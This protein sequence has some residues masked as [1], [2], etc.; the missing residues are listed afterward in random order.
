ME[1][2]LSPEEPSK[3]KSDGLHLERWILIPL[4][5]ITAFIVI[6]KLLERYN[7][8]RNR[9]RADNRAF[10]DSVNKLLGNTT[11][12]PEELKLAEKFETDTLP[13]I[14]KTGL[15]KQFRRNE[16]MTFVMVDGTK[17]ARQDYTMKADLIF[18]IVITNK[19][20]G[21]AS[22]LQVLDYQTGKLYANIRP[23]STVEM[24]D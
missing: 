13:T 21:Y 14:L 20:R 1:N 3:A 23:P 2:N 16:E 12:T 5:A 10:A 17:W 8:A 22:A 18:E 6:D 4:I 15:I 24:Y 7:S 19:V 11:F 9:E